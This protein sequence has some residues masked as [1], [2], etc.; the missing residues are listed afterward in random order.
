[1]EDFFIRLNR[2]NIPIN[3][4][5]FFALVD[6]APYV[7]DTAVYKK[8]ISGNG[9]SLKE[10]KDI[11]SRAAIPYPLFFAP[12]DK[13]KRQIEDYE[14]SIHD[15]FPSKNEIALSHRGALN[16]KEIQTIIADLAK[17]QE[18]LKKYV[19]Q[20]SEENGYTGSLQKMIKTGIDD[21]VKIAEAFR[22]FFDIGKR[23]VRT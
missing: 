4:E 7:K 9:I 11:A 14:N 15:K 23:D 19:L 20:N 2:E 12:L 1:M 13:A 22:A 3:K 18:F 21:N 6:L 5:V 8:A 10:L 16:I 17:K